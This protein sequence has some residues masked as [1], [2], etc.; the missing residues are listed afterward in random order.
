MDTTTTQS[1]WMPL[2]S[3]RR[4]GV[5]HVWLVVL[6]LFVVAAVAA[7]TAGCGEEEKPKG[8]F[9][10]PP[11]PGSEEAVAEVPEDTEWITL[12]ENPKW[13]PVK[14]LLERYR[15]R[16][17]GE[18]KNPM[19]THL[20]EFVEPPDIDPTKIE[21][22]QAETRAILDEPP[23]LD[24]DI[25]DVRTSGPIER[26]ELV[27][28]MSG[29]PRPKAVM[30]TADGTRIDLERGDPIGIEGGRVKAIL[31]YKM[32]VDVPGENV[33]REISIAPPLVS[34]AQ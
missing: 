31:Q 5:G 19:M 3:T 25:N 27:L 15:L 12:G 21:A 32:L 13:V 26:Y 16:N 6:P 17:I 34:F 20:V 11:E 1:S 9:W 7:V 2:R 33:T 23:Q 14:P 30:V 8:T 4:G 18:L 10:K 29:T 24:V 22:D 28:L